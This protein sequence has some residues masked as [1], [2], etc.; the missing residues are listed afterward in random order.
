MRKHQTKNKFKRSCLAFFYCIFFVF[1]CASAQEEENRPRGWNGDV[2]LGIALA[3]G[4]SNTTNISLSFTAEKLLTKTIEWANRGS[5]LLG[6]TA[7]TKN[8]ESIEVTSTAKWTHTAKLFSLIEITVLQDKF[9]NYTY[10]IIP[11]LGM[12]YTIIRSDTAEVSLK[13]GISGVFTKF[14]DSGEKDYFN[15]LMMG[16]E[17]IW[18][19]SPTAEFLQNF[20]INSNFAQLN[21]YFVRLEMSLSAAIA[22]GWALKLSLID[23]YESLPVGEDIKKNDLIF[24]TNLSLKF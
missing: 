21:N 13:S 9:K 6:R 12:G 2:S 19:I 20:T 3:R 22:K 18:K 1:T 10:R 5:Y 23:K 15:A 7:E 8:S 16:N 14:E 17:F 4:N 24:L 11:H